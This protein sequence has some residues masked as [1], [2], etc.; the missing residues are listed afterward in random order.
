MNLDHL[1]HRKF[2]TGRF[3]LQELPRVTIVFAPSR[4]HPHP[5]HAI[6]FSPYHPTTPLCFLRYR[7]TD[8]QH[9]NNP[10]IWSCSILQDHGCTVGKCLQLES[11]GDLSYVSH[12]VFFFFWDSNS[13]AAWCSM[14]E[15]S[16]FVFFPQLCCYFYQ[17]DNSRTVNIS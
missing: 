6:W 14:P 11:Q 10:D 17:K 15:N 2:I 4:P 16:Y 5:L 8:F 12:G 13:W 7:H 3:F 9:F 1:L